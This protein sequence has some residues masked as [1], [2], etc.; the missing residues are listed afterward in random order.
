MSLS[1]L[2]LYRTSSADPR[3]A[4]VLDRFHNASL[5]VHVRPELL[6]SLLISICGFS[7]PIKPYDDWS[8]AHSIWRAA[9]ATSANDDFLQ[10]LLEIQ[11]RKSDN[12]DI[13][14]SQSFR[15]FDSSLLTRLQNAV[16]S[17]LGGR[18][19][20]FHSAFTILQSERKSNIGTDIVGILT[21]AM[22]VWAS[23]SPRL[24]LAPSVTPS[25]LW[26]K[27]WTSL[28]TFVSGETGDMC[29]MTNR[30]CSSVLRL[31]A[32]IHEIE[33]E[34]PFT[35]YHTVIE[36][37]LQ[38]AR[39]SMDSP[40]TKD[41]MDLDLLDD[42]VWTS[43][44]TQKGYS[45]ASTS[46]FRQ[47][48]PLNC[49]EAGQLASNR[50][51]LATALQFVKTKGTLVPAAI[52][53]IIDEIAALEPG[54]LLAARGAVS[55]LLALKPG[56]KRTDAAQLLKVLGKT[57]LEQES[58][59]RCEAALCFCLSV[60]QG[61]AS[62]WVSEDE[63]DPVVELAF[64]VYNYTLSVTLGKFPASSRVLSQ[65]SELLH[66]LLQLNPNYG[67]E[68]LASPRTSLLRILQ[69]AAPSTK[70]R[71]SG[72]LFQLFEKFI[73]TQHE[74]IF[75][76]IVDN[77][78]SDPDN[79]EGI[80]ARLHVLS[81]LGAR[82][83]T[84]LRQATY[85][86]F[87]TAANV[88]SATPLARWCISFTSEKLHLN[89]S[90]E[91][92]R[93]FVPQISYTWLSKDGI[94][95][96]P[97]QAFGYATLKDMVLDNLQEFVGQIALRGSTGADEL[98]AI[99]D[100]SWTSLLATAFPV[101]LAYTLSSETSLPKQDRLYDGSEKLM[102]K[103]LGSELYLQ[104]LRHWMPD[105]VAQLIISLQ[106]DR[107]IEKAFDKNQHA[108]ALSA[109]EEMSTQSTTN[110]E[111]PLSQ[112]PSFR[113]RCLGEELNYI[114]SRLELGQS[115]IWSP[116]LAVHVYRSL[117]S[118]AKPA[119]G[120][121]HACTIIRKI[122]IAVSLAGPIAVTG[123]PL[124]MLLHNLRPYLTMFECAEDTMGIFRYLL[125]HGKSHLSSRISF[126]AGLGVS[127]FASL[128]GF[129]TSSQESTT[130]ESHFLATISKAQEF[131]L[132]L[133]QFLEGLIFVDA[134]TSTLT[135]FK[136]I[137]QHAKNITQPG[138]SAR[139]TSE[140]C[141]LLA[142]LD[143]R[144]SASPLLTTLHFDISLEIL[145]RNFTTST[146]PSDDILVDDLTAL[147]SCM[148]LNNALKSINTNEDFRVWAASAIGRGYL[149]HGMMNNCLESPHTDFELTTLTGSKPDK[150]K[151]REDLLREDM[152]SSYTSI[153]DLLID[154]LWRSDVV[155]AAFAE[156]TLQL[157]SSNIAEQQEGDI[158]AKNF[159]RSIFVELRF[160]TFPCPTIPQSRY[161][162]AA[163]TNQDNG[164]RRSRDSDKWAAD[165]LRGLCSDAMD[166]PVLRHIVPLI[167]EVP[168][169]ANTFFPYAVHVILAGEPKLGQRSRD[170][171]SQAFSSVLKKEIKEHEEAR[172]LVLRTILYLR[173]RY[174]VNETTMAQR[175]SW[176]DVDFTQAVIAATECQM[177]HEALLF[178]EIHHSQ[179]R[180]QGGRSSRKSFV[181][182][183]SSVSHAIET[184][185][186]ENVDDLD[187][188]YGKHADSDLH[189]VL[190]K[191]AH[192]GASQKA[193]S[194]QSAL[195]DSHL[196][197]E[198][199]DG[200]SETASVT[201]LALKSANMHGVA[202]AVKQY[203]DN[204]DQR[205]Q[206]VQADNTFPSMTQWDL[207]PSN[208]VPG[209]SSDIGALFRNMHQA[210]SKTGLE[211]ALD[212]SML[213]LVARLTSG[214]AGRAKANT[215]LSSLAVLAEARQVL[216]ANTQQEVDSVWKC[217]IARD[218]QIQ[219]A[220]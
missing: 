93:L 184:S 218:K 24:A 111:L 179:A 188:F 60:V 27:A 116:A 212:Q 98:A 178:L 39:N 169:V 97:F 80:A 21:V 162:A 41:D 11:R 197:I 91:L 204:P 9:I 153:L 138:S 109:W 34:W 63:G 64:D 170:Q 164:S 15:Q 70:F 137:I 201:A 130:Q 177:F 13:L 95:R 166:D 117:L 1:T 181:S 168:S 123:Y 163:S 172:P 32:Q 52:S 122:R 192:E 58:F 33:A 148:V 193:L 124:E 141:L 5:V 150:A 28:N 66:L 198:G 140:G 142:L 92:F 134:S 174:L 20:E 180:L 171:L 107:A 90:T 211:S 74:A 202:E 83:H 50:I 51:K 199:A 154:L 62:L 187:F 209:R 183:L 115:E 189:S 6:Y 127:I 205:F 143:D 45:N 216:T 149:M 29:M 215:I 85:H 77:L 49:D 196:S 54:P 200:L 17:L 144:S 82:W 217:V 43:Q 126:I 118:K 72:K 40:L 61:L 119:L 151:T 46:Q 114:C 147:R 101:A 75:D 158:L 110:L 214:T 65:F 4:S 31:H 131:R 220:E 102:R 120:P 173:T 145:C 76:D 26:K 186:Y 207:M 194:F 12:M 23:L 132:F 3:E 176:L 86:L 55:E 195:L 190:A 68:D 42:D 185:I 125:Q 59:E 36:S 121:L 167:S 53:L 108:S 99:T 30:I 25:E 152:V 94:S 22:T 88:P 113:A 73:L 146:D 175:N 69:I 44:S 7:E 16:A 165:L 89:S 35:E 135:M 133:S 210:P 38:L 112:Q 161:Q 219:L 160:Q 19:K 100:D 128:T 48:I 8:P 105:I 37:S 84:V 139:S 71:L 136:R 159:D 191:L 14:A 129:I 10:Y 87:E 203:Y 208:D 104:L 155:A 56:I 156:K 213:D 78:P 106:N 81:Q 47:A 57:Y 103:Q 18:L 206:V 182:L 96:M 157:I 79:K 67:T 2:V